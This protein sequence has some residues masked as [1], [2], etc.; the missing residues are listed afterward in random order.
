MTQLTAL[1]RELLSYVEQLAQSSA[2]SATAMLGLEEHS[3]KQTNKTLELLTDCMTSLSQSQ[4]LSLDTLRL[5]LSDAATYEQVE[6]ALANSLKQL[7]NAETRLKNSS[8]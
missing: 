2:Q 3:T 6:K 5:W 4:Q 8:K 7:Q 1:E